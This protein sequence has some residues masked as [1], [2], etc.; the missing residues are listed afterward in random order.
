MSEFQLS[1]ST[2]AY[3]RSRP[4]NIRDPSATVL[5]ISNQLPIPPFSG[6]QLREFQLLQRLC[7]SFHIHF[8]AFT[9][10]GTRDQLNTEAFLEHVD[11]V[12]LIEVRNELDVSNIEPPRVQRFRC[13]YGRNVIDQLLAHATPDLIHVEGYFLMQHVP[14]TEIPI[15]LAEENIEYLLDHD[16]SQA[17]LQRFADIGRTRELEAWQRATLCVA[18]TPEDVKVISD[19]DPHIRVRCV[20]SGFD[21]LGNSKTRHSVTPPVALYAGN[22]AWGPSED[23]VT[24]CSMRCGQLSK[25]HCRTRG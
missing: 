15:V 19:S 18:V 20:G 21:H 14:A 17:E 7:I 25:T 9:C 10:D 5:Y 8:V 2:C 13:T 24:T 16:A 1:P 11:S 3:H 23:G 6:G 4:R 12:T 22:Y